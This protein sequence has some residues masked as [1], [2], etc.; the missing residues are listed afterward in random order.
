MGNTVDTK[1]KKTVKT[2]KAIIDNPDVRVVEKQNRGENVPQKKQILIIRKFKL[3][4][5][6]IRLSFG[7]NTEASNLESNNLSAQ[8]D[9]HDGK[10]EFSISKTVYLK[11][12]NLYDGVYYCRYFE[13]YGEAREAFFTQ[14]IIYDFI[15]DFDYALV[16][17]YAMNNYYG[18]IK[19]FE[20]VRI[21]VN[22]K[23]VKHVS[24]DLV[25]K[26]FNLRNELVAEGLQTLLMKDSAGKLA[27]APAFIRERMKRY[28]VVNA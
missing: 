6:Y 18:E 28:E 19:S 24:S 8:S 25:F 4:L 22:T 1:T 10:N 27:K 12:I 13:W 21:T 16:T 11:D 14:R 15:D 2:V 26:V 20:T 17:K 9:T 5:K 7:F 3:L 23:N